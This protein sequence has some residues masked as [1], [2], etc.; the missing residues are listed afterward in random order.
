MI[1]FFNDKMVVKNNMSTSEDKSTPSDNVEISGNGNSAE[2]FNL[3]QTVQELSDSLKVL[4][5]ANGFT[6][7]NKDYFF[8]L[9]Q[10]SRNKGIE[11][12]S[13]MEKYNQ[14]AAKNKPKSHFPETDNLPSK[15]KGS[16]AKKTLV[17][18]LTA[19]LLTG[20]GTFYSLKK[21]YDECVALK[22]ENP[23]CY[24]KHAPVIGS[25]AE[26]AKSYID[27][28]F[29]D[30]TSVAENT[31]SAVDLKT[32]K[33]IGLETGNTV[34]NPV[35]GNT[36][37]TQYN[38]LNQNSIDEEGNTIQPVAQSS[39]EP[40][41]TATSNVKEEKTN[42]EH[43]SPKKKSSHAKKH[44]AEKSPLMS[45]GYPIRHPGMYGFT[46]DDASSAGMKGNSFAEE[47]YLEAKVNLWDESTD[48]EFLAGDAILNHYAP[49]Y[50][51][52]LKGVLFANDRSTLEVMLD[53]KGYGKLNVDNADIDK[54]KYV[55]ITSAEGTYQQN[56]PREGGI[57]LA[58]AKYNVD[59]K[60]KKIDERNS[61]LVESIDESNTSDISNFINKDIQSGDT[62]EGKPKPGNEPNSSKPVEN[63]SKR[64]S[65]STISSP[66]TNQGSIAGQALPVSQN[67]Y[68]LSIRPEN[69]AK[70]LDLEKSVKSPDDLRR[71]DR[72]SK[73]NYN[74]DYIIHVDPINNELEASTPTALN[75]T[76]YDKKGLSI[77]GTL[78][79]NDKNES[80][81]ERKLIDEDITVINIENPLA[82]DYLVINTGVNMPAFFIYNQE[83][84]LMPYQSFTS[85]HIKDKD[86]QDVS[87]SDANIS[88][89]P[90]DYTLKQSPEKYLH[91]TYKVTLTIT[92]LD[93]QK[94]EVKL[95]ARDSQEFSIGKE[96]RG[97]DFK[98]DAHSEPDV[99]EIHIRINIEDKTNQNNQPANN[100]GPNNDS[101]DNA[102]NPQSGNTVDKTNTQNI[103]KNTSA[104]SQASVGSRLNMAFD[105]GNANLSSKYETPAWKQETTGSRPSFTIQGDYKV[106]DNS[107]VGASINYG[108]EK[109]DI[110]NIGEVKTSQANIGLYTIGSLTSDPLSL[111]YYLGYN[112]L[113]GNSDIKVYNAEIKQTSTT[114]RILL[115]CLLNNGVLG[116]DFGGILNLNRIEQNDPRLDMYGQNWSSW[117]GPYL[118]IND[119]IF[120]IFFKHYNAYN[121]EL[122]RDLR[123]NSFGASFMYATPELGFSAFGEL[124]AS[125][126]DLKVT[127]VGV[128]VSMPLVKDKLY[129]NVNG[130]YRQDKYP[131]GLAKV[132]KE[133]SYITGG[134]STANYYN[135]NPFSHIN[136][137]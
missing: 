86:G 106:K 131:E 21:G 130:G 3:E 14:I 79:V 65:G 17:G 26:Y 45:D 31:K 27:D 129:F 16:W 68:T 137:Q 77:N 91:D 70:F 121:Y 96:D 57:V 63:E 76:L 107:R 10:D 72:L 37:K 12:K 1:L 29:N 60:S 115:N 116:A 41:A 62:S 38:V 123:G 111:D 83:G 88:L 128:G 134:I 78:K 22:T 104:S 35:S 51:S 92:S 11:D 73:H 93:G 15:K 55:A 9:L 34:S 101:L 114:D 81:L 100:A 109:L 19:G 69:N 97:I 2:A 42:A 102:P 47:F 13:F 113:F 126:D 136:N 18:L 58:S 23:I 89:D 132:N 74:G 52:R 118:S 119:S 64:A 24:V 90:G 49:E 71:T 50:G 112:R 110:K 120:E 7:E 108:E 36:L 53:E 105:A 44:N 122:K 61:L 33:G 30:K 98:V 5:G 99:D 39:I 32:L 25:I 67:Q 8:D 80:E 85:N 127:N 95:G 87:H 46:K 20:A 54:Y 6:K 75:Y 56:N 43:K 133:E 4:S 94:R 28:Y 82:N 66:S 117:F 84:K 59:L 48:V 40:A 125:N 103:D 124:P 135:V